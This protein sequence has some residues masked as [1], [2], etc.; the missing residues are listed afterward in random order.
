MN[1]DFLDNINTIK[2]HFKGDPVFPTTGL[3][4]TFEELK[5]YVPIPSFHEFLIEFNE[6]TRKKKVRSISNINQVIFSSDTNPIK[7]I[8]YFCL[9]YSKK[10]EN[11]IRREGILIADNPENGFNII[12]QWPLLNRHEISTPKFHYSQLLNDI[13]KNIE[14]FQD[15]FLIT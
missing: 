2:I 9:F 5:N 11:N 7:K 14:N 13:L 3:N 10:D 4:L 8:Q 1:S 6:L 12:G 15:L